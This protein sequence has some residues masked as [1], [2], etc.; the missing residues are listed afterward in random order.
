MAVGE[1]RSEALRCLAHVVGHPLVFCLPLV[2]SS[3]LGADLVGEVL[4]GRWHAGVEAHL[5]GVVLSEQFLGG[6]VGWDVCVS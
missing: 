6:P 1:R 2:L 3:G 5:Q 4:S